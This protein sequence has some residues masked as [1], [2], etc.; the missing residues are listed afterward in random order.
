MNNITITI[1]Q[2]VTE[3]DEQS[4]PSI[5]IDDNVHVKKKK[6][7]WRCRYCAAENKLTTIEC[8]QCGEIETRF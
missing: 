5:R 7:S 2:S 4:L 3:D 1:K 6:S 8:R